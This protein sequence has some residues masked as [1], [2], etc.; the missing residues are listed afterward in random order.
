MLSAGWRCKYYKAGKNEQVD[1]RFHN[2]GVYCKDKASTISTLSHIMHVLNTD[3]SD[4]KY[5]IQL[6]QFYHI[7]VFLI[8]LIS[9]FN[10]VDQIIITPVVYINVLWAVIF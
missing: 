7:A 1:F 9:L 8:A 4:E 5:L 10:V 6:L 2:G 3:G